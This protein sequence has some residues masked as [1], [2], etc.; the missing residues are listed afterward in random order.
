MRGPLYRCSYRPTG[1]IHTAPDDGRRLG[2]LQLSEVVRADPS[3]GLEEN[4][5]CIMHHET[6]ERA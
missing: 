6:S 5:F 3:R 1:L 4:T 2:F